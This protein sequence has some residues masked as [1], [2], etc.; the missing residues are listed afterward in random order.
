MSPFNL[1]VALC[2]ASF[3]FSKSLNVDGDLTGNFGLKPV[4]FPKLLPEGLKPV[5]FPKLLPEGLNPDPEDFLKLLLPDGLLNPLLVDA[6][7]FS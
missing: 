3:L 2:S 1:F 7:F 4:L 5:L 6:K